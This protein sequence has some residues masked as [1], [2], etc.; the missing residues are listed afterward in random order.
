[1]LLCAC[2]AASACRGAPCSVRS[3]WRGRR[4]F[5]RGRCAARDVKFPPY[6]MQTLPNGLQVVAV[7]HHEQPAVSMR[8]LVRA[9]SASDPKREARPRAP[10]GVAARSGHR[11]RRGRPARFNDAIDF[12]GGVAGRRRRHR[13]DVPQHGRDEGQLRRRACGCCP[14]WRAT[15]RSR[16]RRSIGSASRLLSGLQVS[17]ED[18]GLHRQRRVRSAR[19]RLSSVRHA[20]DRH[21]GD[22]RARSRATI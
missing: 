17:F 14:T 22:D 3:P 16:R 9:G 21:A 12:I 13:S 8:L 11:R 20:A 10:G 15:R 1:M 2:V 6:Q 5:R 7:L 4:S 18:P 19:L